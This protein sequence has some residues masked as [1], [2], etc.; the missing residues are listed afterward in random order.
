MIITASLSAAASANT[1]ITLTTSGTAT[2]GSD[3]TISSNKITIQAGNT[4]GT[5]TLKINGD[6]TPENSETTVVDI[7][8]VS[9]GNGAYENGTQKTTVVINNDDRYGINYQTWSCGN[10]VSSG[11][12]GYSWQNGMSHI[13]KHS[14]SLGGIFCR[15]FWE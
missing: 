7:T 11:W 14:S 1:D 6:S 10:Y 4:S 3:Y 9:G 5:T 8:N 13:S 2:S 15:S 12:F